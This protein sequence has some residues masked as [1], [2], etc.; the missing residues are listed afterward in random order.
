MAKY[1]YFITHTGNYYF[2]GKYSCPCLCY[3][4]IKNIIATSF[5]III[6]IINL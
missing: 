6:V 2:F 3:F 4:T 5:I 1:Y